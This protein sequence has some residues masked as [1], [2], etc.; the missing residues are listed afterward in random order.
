MVARSHSTNRND[1]RP[2]AAPDS[3]Q[4]HELDALERYVE[5]AQ[6]S[7]I[8]DEALRWEL[9]KRLHVL[10]RPQLKLSDVLIT[11][12]EALLEGG[13]E[14]LGREMGCDLRQV[15]QEVR[16]VT[17]NLV[18]TVRRLASRVLRRHGR[19]PPYYNPN[20]LLSLLSRPR[21]PARKARKT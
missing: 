2:P 14:Q 1:R 16:S 19:R 12:A 5:T 3:F 9:A 10:A 8:P 15:Q 21:A 4:E 18:R 7:S 13:A 17:I 6:W 20:W 11:A